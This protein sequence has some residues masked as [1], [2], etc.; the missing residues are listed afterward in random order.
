MPSDDFWSDDRPGHKPEPRHSKEPPKKTKKVD[1]LIEDASSV[2]ARFSWGGFITIALLMVLSVAVGFGLFVYQS[3]T[4]AADASQ[5]KAVV[6]TVTSGEKTEAILAGMERAGLVVSRYPA[7]VYIAVRNLKLRAGIYSFSPAETSKQMIDQMSDGTM[8]QYRVTIPEGWRTE[9]IGQ[10]LESR[11]IVSAA[12]FIAAAKYD[13]T[14]DTLPPGITLNPGDSLEGLLFPDTYLLA[15]G[16]T[17]KEIVAKMLDNFSTRTKD[18]HPTRDQLVLASIVEREAKLDVDRPKIAGVYQNRL[19]Q[20]MKLQADP[21]VAYAKDTATYQ[22]TTDPAAMTWWSPISV[23]DYTNVA[24]A[25]NTYL[26]A[27][28]PPGPIANPGLKSLTAAVHPEANEYYF[29]L[30]LP[31]G[32]TIYSK[33]QADHTAAKHKYGITG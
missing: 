14:R 3:L 1:A 8:S 7:L 4:G 18:L 23:S 22:G 15:R 11:G 10:M 21:T 27:G 26:H 9:Q 30:N 16:V 2:P 24:S 28:L 32:T 12:D 29:F 33:T 20:N 6:F 13:P 25:Y 17:A 31:D 19:R 5:S